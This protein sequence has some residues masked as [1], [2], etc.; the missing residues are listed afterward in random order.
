VVLE[1]IERH[2]EMKKSTRQAALEGRSEIG[3][4]AITITLVDVVVYLPVAFVS[5][6]IG[7]FF[8]SYGVT[9]AVAVLFSLFVSFTLTPMLAAKW[10]KD[11]SEPEEEPQGLNKIFRFIFRPVGWLW[12]GFTRL[13]E[14][15]FD[16]L[17]RIYAAI[18]RWVLKNFLTQSLVVLLAAASLAARLYLVAAGFVGSEFAPQEDDGQISVS[19]E[20]PPGTNLAATDLAA[21]QVEQ[22]ILNQ[23]PETR[24]ILTKVGSSG[25]D[26]IFG[27][28]GGG[29]AI[30]PI[31]PSVWSIS[32]SVY[33]VLLRS[34]RPFALCSARYLRPILPLLWL[35]PLAGVEAP[36]RSRFSDRT[37]TS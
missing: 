20:M 7:Q 27:G 3:L 24:T 13:W 37:P 30:A 28:G 35:L 6:L 32:G 36:S 15:G 23:V 1:N 18:L 10:L 25:G 34:S 9:M 12:N 17:A 22:I 2:L 4:A 26:N 16:R 14:A 5:G 21:R 33:A 8:F 19:I 29:G 11:E 31:L